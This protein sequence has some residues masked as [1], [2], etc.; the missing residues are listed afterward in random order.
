MSQCSDFS[1][2]LMRC[3]DDFTMKPQ[4]EMDLMAIMISISRAGKATKQAPQTG[5]QFS[6]AVAWHAASG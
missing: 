6:D 3:R 1:I 5:T 2:Q 4:H